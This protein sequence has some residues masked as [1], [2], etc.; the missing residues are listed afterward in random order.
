MEYTMDHDKQV[1]RINKQPSDRKSMSNRFA[2]QFFQESKEELRKR[3]EQALKSIKPVSLKEQ[4]IS[5]KYYPRE[6]DMPKRPLW[7]FNMTKQQL[8]MGEQRYFAVRSYVGFSSMKRNASLYRM[9]Y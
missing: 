9:H 5:D 3:K 7:D 1:Q 2:L 6:I 8:E 4:E